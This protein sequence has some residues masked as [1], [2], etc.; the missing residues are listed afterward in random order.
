MKKITQNLE[1]FFYNLVDGVEFQTFSTY[2]DKNKDI[3]P[4]NSVNID[5]FICTDPWNKTII[6]QNGDVLPC[7]SFYGYEI[8]MGNIKT[9][10]IFNI[11]NSKKFKK[12]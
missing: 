9:D 12:K 3:I 11:Y 8:P 7:C 1:I 10:T 4:S 6:R 5:N 2:Y